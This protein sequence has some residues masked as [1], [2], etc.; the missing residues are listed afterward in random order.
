MS[1]ILK[2]KISEHLSTH[3]TLL[4]HFIPLRTKENHIY[5]LFKAQVTIIDSSGAYWD[6]IPIFNF[7][8]T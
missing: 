7:M 4:D 2:T 6:Q 8:I 3:P 5:N 1:T